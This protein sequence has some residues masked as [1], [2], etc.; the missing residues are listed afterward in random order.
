MGRDVW[1]S[2]LPGRREP[3]RE[4]F[5]GWGG[6]IVSDNFPYEGELPFQD[7]LFVGGDV[8]EV[9][10]GVFLSYVFLSKVLPCNL[11]DSGDGFVVEEFNFS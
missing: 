11:L 4:G 5:L 10:S 6:V 2:F 7:F 8:V 9:F 1:S 3:C